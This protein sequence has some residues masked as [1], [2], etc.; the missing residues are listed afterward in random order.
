MDIVVGFFFFSAGAAL[1]AIAARF[2]LELW[3]DFKVWIEDE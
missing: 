3:V 2:L 1:L